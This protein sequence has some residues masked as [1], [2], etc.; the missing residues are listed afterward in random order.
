MPSVRHSLSQGYLINGHK[1]P[2]CSAGSGA[3]RQLCDGDR[4]CTGNQG[5]CRRGP[6]YCRG[7]AERGKRRPTHGYSGPAGC[8]GSSEH[9]ESGSPGCTSRSSLLR[10][11]EPEARSHVR[12]ASKK[13]G[14]LSGCCSRNAASKLK[15]PPITLAAFFC[16]PIA[17]ASCRRQARRCRRPAGTRECRDR[18]PPF[19]LRRP[20]ADRCAAPRMQQ[21]K[22]A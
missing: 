18:A 11:D 4:L 16:L 12:A 19:A 13:V 21:R 20:S 22:H 5:R 15:K 6:C 3:R 17:R 2:G 7:C 1:N 9:C 8:F 14:K 10:C